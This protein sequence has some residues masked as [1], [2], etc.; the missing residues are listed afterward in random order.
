[1]LAEDFLHIAVPDECATDA[2]V[3]RE[4]IYLPLPWERAGERETGL[5]SWYHHCPVAPAL[6]T[7]AVLCAPIGPEYTRSHRSVRHLAD[8]LARA[9]ISALRF[10]YHGSG[11]SAGSD[12]DPD[13]MGHWRASVAQA[14][15]H[16]RAISGC[17][18]VCLVGIRL[19]ATLAALEA[20]ACGVDRLVLWNPVVKGRGYAREMQAIAMV[21]EHGQGTDGDG[22]ES[23]GFRISGETLAA[24]KAVDLTKAQFPPATRLFVISRDDMAPDRTLPDHLASAGVDSLAATLPG[25]NGMMADHQFTVVPEATIEKIVGWV[26]ENRRPGPCDTAMGREPISARQPLA[27]LDYTEAPR[28]FGPDNRLFGILTRPRARANGRGIVMLNAGSIHH[29][30]PH[31]LYVRLAREAASLGCASLR[32]DFE[33]IGDSVLRSDGVE[34]EPYPDWA[35]ANL[36]AAV[37]LM[38]AE[39]CTEV[40]LLGVCSGAQTAFQAGHEL[41]DLP[42]DRLVLINPWY[43]YRTKGATY[44]PAS[45]HYQDV[46]AYQRS[47]RDTGRWKRLLRGEVDLKR[48][49]RIAGTQVARKAKAAAAELHEVLSPNGGTRLSR[50]LRTLLANG[51]RITMFEG[52]GEPAGAAL[53]TEAKRA[54]RKATR[55]GAMSVERIPGADHTFSRYSARE[56][57]VRRI[58]AVLRS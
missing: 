21:S 25:W 35:L 26:V 34:N 22:I 23:A 18:A 27:P 15:E 4:A 41:P 58:C 5:F 40:I 28:H 42:V 7:V 1:M 47:M 9:G 2:E 19:G 55:S 38:R 12:E 10:D 57:L 54:L 8:R 44:D 37:S 52:E 51:R 33:G 36:Q 11:D 46:A 43:F 31:R 29:V 30:G 50:D 6:G 48:V 56:E 14:V 17:E 3:E 45:H 20:Q 39:G 49:A 13:R 24:L 32:F 16:A 53:Q